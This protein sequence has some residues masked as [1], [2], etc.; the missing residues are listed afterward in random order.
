MHHH[1]MNT[2]P[3]ALVETPRPHSGRTTHQCRVSVPGTRP[4]HVDNLN[5]HTNA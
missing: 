2:T 5:H 3:P 4:D 1:R